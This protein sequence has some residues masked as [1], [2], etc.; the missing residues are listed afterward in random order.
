LIFLI[1]GLDVFGARA[2]SI[3]GLQWIKLLEL[4]YVGVTTGMGNGRYVGGDTPEGKSARAR[5]QL[6]I[7]RIFS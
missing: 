6:E 2:K 4:L 3:W 7:E 1:A 5:V